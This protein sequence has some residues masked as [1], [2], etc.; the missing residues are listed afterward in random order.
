MEPKCTCGI[1]EGMTLAE[2]KSLLPSCTEGFNHPYICPKWDKER[3]RAEK[4]EAWRRHYNKRLK[5]IGHTQEEIDAMPRRKGRGKRSKITP[6][7]VEIDLSD[8]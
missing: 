6:K 5:K 3:R 8:L 2:L 7:V 4:E 1:E